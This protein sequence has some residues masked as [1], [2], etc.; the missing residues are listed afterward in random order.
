MTVFLIVFFLIFCYIGKRNN[1]KA[2]T[3]PMFWLAFFWVLIFGVYFTCG[4]KY[5]YGLSLYSITFLITCIILFLIGYNKGLHQPTKIFKQNQEGLNKRGYNIAGIIGVIIFT[6]EYIRLNGIADKKADSDISV[7]GS[8]A[9]LLVPIL[10]VMGLYLNALSIKKSGSFSILGI[11]LVFAYSIPCMINAGRESILFAIIGIICLYGYRKILGARSK[12]KSKDIKYLWLS[13]GFSIVIYMGFLIVQISQKRFTDNEINMLL[14]ARN[15]SSKAMDE[16]NSWGQFS[17]FYY[18]I[19]SYFS[20]QIPFIDFTLQEY[21][22][23]Y[24]LGMYEL[25]IV[26]RRLPDFLELDYRLAF[27][28]LD[29]LYASKRESFSR[30]WNTVLGSFITDFT[31]IGTIIACSICGYAIGTI[32]NKFKNTLDP[33][34]ATLI[35][36]LCLS[37]FSTIQLGPF[38]QTQIY[39]AY[40]WWYLI[41]RK[42]K[43]IILKR[44]NK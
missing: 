12:R 17:F 35:A 32:R 7:I 29:H 14:T 1:C 24:L 20:H 6:F 3:N 18:N 15:V 26:S 38:F 2:L 42:D 4:I 5:E 8:V 41:F 27:E 9:S 37:S 11:I 19:A 22:G 44:S 23:P 33:R 31:W 16:A 25:N 13:I 36:L 34:Y 43:R 40:I 30:G 10:L 21:D 28:K 39:G